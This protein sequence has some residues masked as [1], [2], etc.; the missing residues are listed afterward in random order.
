MLGFGVGRCVPMQT[1]TASGWHPMGVAQETL[2]HDLLERRMPQ[3][4]RLRVEAVAEIAPS[5]LGQYTE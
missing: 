1:D 5:A 4:H 3:G 2:L